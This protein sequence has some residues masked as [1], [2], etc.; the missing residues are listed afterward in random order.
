M[1]VSFNQSPNPPPPHP[2]P[3]PKNKIDPVTGDASTINNES[4][5]TIGANTIGTIGVNTIGT[6]GVNTIGT[7]GVNTIGTIGVNT[8]GTKGSIDVSMGK[9]DAATFRPLY[10]HISSPGLRRRNS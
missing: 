2:P 5:C 3:I 10:S 1:K 4:L 8:I 9:G 6:I 7:I